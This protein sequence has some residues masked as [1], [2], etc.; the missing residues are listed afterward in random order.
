MR[1]R[2]TFFEPGATSMSKNQK[3]LSKRLKKLS[4]NPQK[5]SKKLRKAL[6]A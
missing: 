3:K 1:T 4:K 6:L 2:Q 5:L